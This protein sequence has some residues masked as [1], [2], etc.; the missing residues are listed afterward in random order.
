MDAPASHDSVSPT[1]GKK[2]KK[3]SLLGKLRGKNN[4][5]KS[6]KTDNDGPTL[7][8]ESDRK[9]IEGVL[10]YG[11]TNGKLVVDSATS[12]GDTGSTTDP[13][14][15]PKQA[16]GDLAHPSLAPLYIRDVNSLRKIHANSEPIRISNE[17]FDMDMVI[18]LR[19]PNVDD[20]TVEP[21]SEFNQKVADYFRVKQRRLEYQFQVKLKKTPENKDLYYA[22]QWEKPVKMGIIQR[23][24]VTACLAFLKKT[25]PSFHY[26]L[27]GSSERSDDGKFEKPHLANFVERGLDR[28]VITKPGGTPP[29][30][31]GDIHEDLAHYKKRKAGKIKVNFNTEDTYTLALWNA[32]VDW[33]NWKIVGIPGIK[34]CSL[35]TILGPQPL[36]IFIYMLDKGRGNSNHFQK[37]IEPIV[38]LEF[39]S[40][41]QHEVKPQK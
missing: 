6:K 10:S 39:S 15:R 20:P 7:Q 25:R 27:G 5:H 30:L 37:D 38:N 11:G 8:E 29:K 18:M 40:D 31:G 2:Q 17:W 9:E 16:V 28:V 14:Q 21:G 12:N 4:K 3:S 33:I 36:N 23:A 1:M 13:D 19:T 24:L 22:V 32:N 34:S 41:H 26:S 35:R